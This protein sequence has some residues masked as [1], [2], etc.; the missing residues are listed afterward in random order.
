MSAWFG[1]NSLFY[2]L[3]HACSLIKVW[4]PLAYSLIKV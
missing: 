1:A 3:W 4:L 2:R